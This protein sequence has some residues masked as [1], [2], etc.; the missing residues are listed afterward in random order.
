MD[1]Q[2]AAFKADVI[3]GLSGEPKTLP[4]RWLYDDHG[5]ELFEQI[6]RLPE[7]YPTRTET[8]ILTTRASELADFCGSRAVVIEYGAGASVKSQILLEALQKPRVFV[9]I[10]IAGDFLAASAI[11]LRKRFP[12]LEVLPFAAD[13][14]EEF[15]LPNDVPTGFP[16]TGF[17]AGSTIG[18]LDVS[19][20]TRFLA[21]VRRHVSEAGPVPERWPGSGYHG[22]RALIGIDLKKSTAT[23]IP[24]YDD[25]AGVT[26]AFNLNL[27]TRINRELGGTFDT[28]RFVHEA[29]WNE[30]ASAIEMHIVSEAEQEATVAGYTFSFDAGESIHTES[31]RKYDI[32]GFGRMA[33]AAGWRIAET[34]TDDSDLFAIVGLEVG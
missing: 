25:A 13:F 23:L 7:Y 18:N 20:A 16:R 14:T 22:G 27:L 30:D 34:W 31:S 1:S 15:D 8:S 11:R 21:R 17:F 29:R 5:S 6:T 2:T 24:A 3:A 19:E 32:D 33:A 4:S 9:P 12:D 10:D 26:A 28:A